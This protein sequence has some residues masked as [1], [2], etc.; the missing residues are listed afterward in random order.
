MTMQEVIL[1][2]ED[3]FAGVAGDIAV[4]NIP[5]EGETEDKMAVE[6][7]ASFATVGPSKFSPNLAYLLL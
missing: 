4:V 6:E 1:A 7:M 3:K 5:L 2:E